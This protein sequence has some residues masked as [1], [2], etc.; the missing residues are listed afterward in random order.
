MI[1]SLV[2]ITVQSYLIFLLYSA[3]RL[4]LKAKKDTDYPEIQRWMLHAL[5]VLL[6]LGATTIL[7][8]IHQME[9]VYALLLFLVII[10]VLVGRRDYV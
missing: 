3:V 9:L 2:F 4:Y 6:L 8:I 7:F 5:V 10:T 1:P